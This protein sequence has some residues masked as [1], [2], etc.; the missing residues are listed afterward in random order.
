MIFDSITVAEGSNIKNMVVDSGGTLP[1]SAALGELFYR[2]LDN[3]LYIHTDKGW[4]NVTSVASAMTLGTTSCAIGYTYTSLAGFN[5]I[6]ATTFIGDLNGTANYAAVATNIS[7]GGV[8]YIPVQV[9][10]NTTGFITPGTAGYVLTANGVGNTPTWQPGNA[11]AEYLTGTALSAS[12][13][14]SSLSSLGTI[15]TGTWHG[16]TIAT[17]Y[18]GTGQ[19]SYAVGDILFANGS[20]SL[21]KLTIGNSGDVLT[22]AN[23]AP[24]WAALGSNNNAGN[25][26]GGSGGS[27]PYQ[28]TADTTTFLN[29][30]SDGQ[31]LT[32]S[33]GIPSW[34]NPISGI[35]SVVGTTNQITVLTINGTATLSF[36]TNVSIAGTI[37]AG[38]FS[39]TI[40]QSTNL[41]GGNIGYLPYQAGANSTSFIAPGTA[42]YVLTSNGGGNAPSW[43]ASASGSSGVTIGSTTISG[44]GSTSILAGLSAVTSTSFVGTISTA[45]QPN[46]TSVGTL[47]SLDV[48]GA[49]THHNGLEVGYLGIPQNVQG[50]YT[51]S[52]SDAGK[53]IFTADGNVTWTIPSHLSITYAIG[54]E[55]TFINQSAN[56]CTIV[57]GDTM[58]L[59]GAGTVGAHTLNAWSIA[60][61]IKT[62]LMTWMISE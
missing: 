19:T 51:C 37:T 1:V 39:G 3:T 21:A 50:N 49:I 16:S 33:G 42:G 35:S 30:G 47:N 56:T 54:T 14:G 40:S 48:T 27:L 32:A 59:A 36:P 9:A 44:G 24:V 7:S 20:S 60:K 29:I 28:S 41:A 55:I 15:T 38:G 52:L 23:G 57:C 12:I 58:Y 5:S 46:I 26:I 62:S 11:A 53:H 2:T 61:V 31:V 10:S 13:T 17:N 43:Q 25:I 18:G 8:G 4:H 6:A 34:Q 22:I 45:S